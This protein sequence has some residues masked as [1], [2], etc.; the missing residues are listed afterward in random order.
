MGK[1]GSSALDYGDLFGENGFNIEVGKCFLATFVSRLPLLQKS[2]HAEGDSTVV[3]RFVGIGES[4]SKGSGRSEKAS[5]A[6]ETGTQ[7]EKARFR[8]SSEQAF[9]I[10]RQEWTFCES[11]ASS[12]QSSGGEKKA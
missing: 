9:C 11:R 4:E 6:P 10:G 5:R 2:R 12:V 1:K 8:Y 7:E 3:C